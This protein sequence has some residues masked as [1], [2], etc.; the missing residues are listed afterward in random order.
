MKVI[1]AIQPI[2][3]RKYER[4]LLKYESKVVTRVNSNF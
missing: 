2:E 3:F 4:E 1:L